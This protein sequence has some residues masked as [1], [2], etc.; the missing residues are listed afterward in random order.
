M[1]TCSKC[2]ITKDLNDFYKTKHSK[3]G[4]RSQCKICHMEGSKLWVKNN[5]ERY[6]AIVRKSQLKYP[7]Y[8]KNW[9]KNNYQKY[10][11]QIIKRRNAII[12]QTPVWADLT[13]IKQFYR[14]CPIGHKVDHILP[15]QGKNVSGLNIVTN[16]QYLTP[17]ENSK[18]GN[19]YDVK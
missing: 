12:R 18:K 5:R 2:R 9:R 17:S 15:I 16:M 11:Q 7:E 6:N 19:R 8:R 1:K 4:L 10:L 3:D 13:A 14:N